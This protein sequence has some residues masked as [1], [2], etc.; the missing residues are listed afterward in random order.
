MKQKHRPDRKTKT[1][2]EGQREGSGRYDQPPAVDMRGAGTAA[3]ARQA[4]T[5]GEEAREQREW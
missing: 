3:N 2:A 4:D 1:E 5:R